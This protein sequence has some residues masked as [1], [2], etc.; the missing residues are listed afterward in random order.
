VEIED[1]TIET[2]P[3]A[4]PAGAR[5]MAVRILKGRSELPPA[6]SESLGKRLIEGVEAE[7]TRSTVTIPA[8]QIGNEQPIRI[9]SERWYAPSLKVIVESRRS[10]PRFGETSYRLT[11]IVRAEPAP[12][13]FEVPSD[14]KVIDEPPDFFFKSRE[15]PRSKEP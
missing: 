9:V 2:A 1:N 14:F 13:L 12:S 3:P 6:V 5:R 4:P 8:G 7:G 10:D 11:K 15:V